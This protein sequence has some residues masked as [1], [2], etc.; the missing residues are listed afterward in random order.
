MVG[1]CG[2]LSEPPE[3][4]RRA[5]NGAGSRPAS[6]APAYPGAARRGNA[7]TRSPDPPTSRLPMA[8]ARSREVMDVTVSTPS[9]TSAQ[10][11]ESRL[12]LANAAS[13]AQEWQRAAELWDGLRA[14]F[15]HDARCWYEAGRAYCEIGRLDHADRILDQA[16]GLFPDDERT[17]YWRVIAARRKGD[18]REVLKRA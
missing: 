2:A 3:C 13:D 17:A 5:A 12:A 6:V 11:L 15:P 1:A 8:A 4:R 16:I 18:W 7:P 14:D 10:S 9:E